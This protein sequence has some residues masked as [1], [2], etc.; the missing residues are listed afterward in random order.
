MKKFY[1]FKENNDEVELRIE[2]EIMSDD[3]VWIAE[4]F[5][6]ESTT[7]NKFKE[8]LKNYEDKDITVWIDS[9]GGDVFAGAGIYNALKEHKGNVTVKIDGKAISAAS[10]IAMAGDVIEMSPVA[11]MMIHNP[12]SF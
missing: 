8:Q 12:M 11:I 6:V 1:N 5:G 9:F 10:V 4:A 7:P 2:G 3:D